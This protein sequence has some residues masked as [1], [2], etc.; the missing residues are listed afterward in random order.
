MQDIFS[1][2]SLRSKRERLEALDRT[3][4]HQKMLV[5]SDAKAALCMDTVKV[6]IAKDGLTALPSIFTRVDTSQRPPGWGKWGG[7]A[8]VQW[9]VACPQSQK[10][11]S[12][13]VNAKVG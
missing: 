9:W 11:C 13:K 8:Q 4:S 10:I 7:E 3:G 5:Y 12:F 6:I 2:A 1:I